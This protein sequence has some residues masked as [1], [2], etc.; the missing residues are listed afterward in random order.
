MT[1]TR[2]TYNDVITQTPLYPPK[3]IGWP[4]RLT[5]VKK[6]TFLQLQLHIRYSYFFSKAFCLFNA[7]YLPH[8][9]VK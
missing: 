5:S 1:I 4:A 7:S 6:K 8:E 9:T 2:Y 3:K